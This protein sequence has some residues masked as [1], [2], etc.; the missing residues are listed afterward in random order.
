MNKERDQES[1]PAAAMLACLTVAANSPEPSSGK[2]LPAN[3]VSRRRLTSVNGISIGTAILTL[4]SVRLRHQIELRRE[5]T[6]G[7]GLVWHDAGFRL[8][9][10]QQRHRFAVD[11]RLRGDGAPR[12]NF[13]PQI[14][15]P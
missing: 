11:L 1:S 6:V 12:A 9:A 14:R 2:V 4:P 10:D 15:L 3:C 7:L 13:E 5:R 8:H